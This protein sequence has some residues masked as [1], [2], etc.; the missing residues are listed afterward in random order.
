MIVG[1]RQLAGHSQR[2]TPDLA[3]AGV[4]AFA[5]NRRDFMAEGRLEGIGEVSKIQFWWF[6]YKRS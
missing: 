3:Q 4:R 5:K 1:R 6:K 2:S